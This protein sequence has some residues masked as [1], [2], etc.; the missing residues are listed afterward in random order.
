MPCGLVVLRETR[1][2]DRA[3]ATLLGH[4]YGGAVS[5]WGARDGRRVTPLLSFPPPII[6]L[7]GTGGRVGPRGVGS[8]WGLPT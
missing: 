1:R 4:R 5:A 7:A 3:A 8:A 6:R 2:P